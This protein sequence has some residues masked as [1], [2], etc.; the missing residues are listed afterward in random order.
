[1]PMEPIAIA[2]PAEAGLGM[3]ERRGQDR[4]RVRPICTPYTILGGRRCLA[5]RRDEH[6][7]NIVDQ[8]GLALFVAVASVA[9]LN[10]LDAFYT[11]LFLSYGG[12]ELNPV[13]DWILCTGGVWLF[14]VVKSQ[15]IGACVG[16]LTVT[17]NFVASR[18][19]LSIVLVGYVALLFWH[20][21]LMQSISI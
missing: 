6:R 5:R 7:G 20:L 2:L 19:G 18:I 8:H 13:V 4:R 11:V 21:Y 12:T 17:K 16:F 14:L 1:M 9:V 3:E 10:V 15:G